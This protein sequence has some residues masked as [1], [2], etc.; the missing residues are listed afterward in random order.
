MPDTHADERWQPPGT[1]YIR[2]WVG[3]PLL[4]KGQLIG[5]LNIDSCTANTYDSTTGDIVMVFANLAAIAIENV[6]LFE[7][8][9]AARTKAEAL[10][11]ADEQRLVELETVRRAS[12]SLTS[13]LELPQVLA[14][15]LKGALEVLP[16]ANSG[17][18]YL[19]NYDGDQQLKFGAFRSAQD[20]YAWPFPGPRPN[21]LTNTVARTGEVIVVSEMRT[22]PLF[23]DVQAGWNGSVIGL[24]LKIGQRVV[25]VM[26]ID[27]RHP[28]SFLL[29]ELHTLRLLGDQAAIAIENARLFQQASTKR[30]QLSLLYDISRELATTVDPEE[31]LHRAITLTCQALDG[32]VGMIF[33]YRREEDRLCLSALHGNW[34]APLEEIDA[35]LG[36]SSR[37]GL[38]GWVLRNRQVAIVPDV[39][40]NQHWARIP[41]L[42][43]PTR[44]AISAPIMDGKEI[45]GVLTVLSERVG[46]F[47]VDQRA[48]MQAICNEIGLALGN[49]WRYEQVERLAGLL[50]AEQ[51][52]LEE[53]VQHLPVG[54]LLLDQENNLLKS[55][56]L[57]E[58]IL[59]EFQQK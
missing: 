12:L 33:L 59:R 20:F 29:A 27:F 24:P 11:A 18:I 38:E 23:S 54:V 42:S 41:G 34:T 58:E 2:S 44:S 19:Y 53:L 32:L 22:H 1:E 47:S 16:E 13:S 49:A 3:A 28:R 14:A 25:G 51:K 46:A 35:R 4:V 40:Q 6:Q 10:Q 48:L 31:I 39:T 17:N 5:L 21:G 57:G 56:P 55:N 9:R 15:I 30:R 36:L 52:Q 7:A 43:D 8:E 26:N 45:L 50:S 37:K